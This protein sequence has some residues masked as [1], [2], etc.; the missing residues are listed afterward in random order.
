MIK[1]FRLKI[2]RRTNDDVFNFMMRTMRMNARLARR[3]YDRS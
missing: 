2:L 3:E 1:R